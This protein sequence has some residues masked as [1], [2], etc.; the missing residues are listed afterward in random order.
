MDGRV[1]GAVRSAPRRVPPR[2]RPLALVATELRSCGVA[3]TPGAP[4]FPVPL[5]PGYEGCGVVDALGAGVTGLAVGDACVFMPQH[6]CAATHLVLPVRLVVTVDAAKLAAA[7]PER[8]ACLVLT[9]VTAYQQLH[10]HAGRE[11]LERPGASILVHGAAGGT[12]AMLVELA[13]LAGVKHVYGTCNARNLEAVRAQGATAID[14]ATDW[15]AEVKRLTGGRGVDVLLD[16]VVANGYLAKGLACTARGGIYLAYGFTDSSTPGVFSMG[17]AAS[18]MLRLSL[19][20]AVS[21]VDGRAARFTNVS[22]DRDTRPNEFADDVRALLSLVADGKLEP[23]VG[24][25]WQLEQARD[26]W[27]AIEAGTHRGKQ[28]VRIA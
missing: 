26:A 28:V 22:Q 8:T 5:T 20:N 4:Q 13:K 14:Y 12:G 21:C 10:R 9:G 16:A 27:L 25:V 11:R 17:T 3:L 7:T 18:A 23:V 15:E 24:R 2:C 1:R 19:Q 6:G